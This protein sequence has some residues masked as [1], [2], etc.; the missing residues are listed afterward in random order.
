MFESIFHILS[1]CVCCDIENQIGDDGF[2][3]IVEALQVNLTL[4]EIDLAGE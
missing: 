1:D 4:L 2:I 3:A